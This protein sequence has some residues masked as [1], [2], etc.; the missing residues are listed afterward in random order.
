MSDKVAEYSS[1]LNE[2]LRAVKTLQL[3]P[4]GHPNLD[5]MLEKC[6]L[7]LREK[8]V[9][10]NEVKWHIDSTGFYYNGKQ[11]LEG[12]EG[13]L[14]L[15]REFFVRKTSEISFRPDFTVNELKSFLGLLSV[16]HRQLFAMGG[17]EVY[18]AKKDV[19]GILL[20]EMRYEDLQKLIDDLK[21]KKDVELA[22]EHE[23]EVRPIEEVKQL[24]LSELL[25]LLD[26]E[27]DLLKYS[28]L[29]HKIGG[30]TSA[31]AEQHNMKA[32]YVV[33]KTFYFHTLKKNGKPESVVNIAK[34]KMTALFD[35]E[36]ASFLVEQL[37]VKEDREYASYQE[38]L[39]RG[40]A[41]AQTTLLD[42]LLEIGDVKHRRNVFNT[43][44][45]FG[46]EV[47]PEIENR[48]KDPRWFAV[49]QMVS[50]LGELGG[51]RSLTLLEETYAKH[52][53]IRVKK[54]VLK[55]VTRIPSK[56]SLDLLLDALK[57]KDK[58]I[59]GQA[60]ISLAI[61][62]DPAGVEPLAEIAVKRDMFNENAE[63]RKEAVKALGSLGDN[64]AVPYLKNVLTARV[65][66]GRAAY[67]ELRN[68]ACM[69]LGRIG[70]PDALE[71]VA[72]AA[73]R[74]GEA[75]HVTCR[76]ILEGKRT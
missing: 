28:E 69:S 38:L 11:L 37:A 40:G 27:T 71:A 12:R 2:L 36:M 16:D 29:C 31:L 13:A 19:K 66:F 51:D 52:P 63:L 67:E 48:M 35:K 22:E 54:E 50:L 65:W 32:L 53:D 74:Y 6:S 9:E 46:D 7:A 4:H 21:D 44:V 62:K 60:V 43:V 15:A 30:K 18:L 1:I 8:A 72:G 33:L 45:L 47:R 57:S 26:K 64:R 5:D 55:T 58:A 3:Y 49:R 75:L 70:T 34:S 73:D 56:R 68:L 25:S 23:E 24:S 42:R 59:Q 14:Q 10:E 41:L 20:N 17:A 61:L 39:L 76:R